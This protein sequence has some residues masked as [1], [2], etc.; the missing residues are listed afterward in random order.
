MNLKAAPYLSMEGLETIF[1]L[2]PNLW[3]NV[4]V[5]IINFFCWAVKSPKLLSVMSVSI[6]LKYIADVSMLRVVKKLKN[7]VG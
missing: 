2:A 1:V 3:K 5:V 7:H 4:P 6:L